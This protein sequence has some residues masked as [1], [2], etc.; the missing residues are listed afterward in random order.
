MAKTGLGRGLGALLGGQNPS[1]TAE[2]P[3]D[4]QEVTE[5]VPANAVREVSI[6]S[7]QPCPSQP[8]KDFERQPLEELAA[9]IEVN[10]IL[11]PLVA[12]TTG[13]GQL[14]LIAGERRWRAAQIAGLE[15]VPVIVREASDSQVLELALVENLQ[16][17]DLNPVE[18]AQ[19]YALLMEAFDLTQEATA[20][21]VGKSR[22][23]VANAVRLLNLPEP[24][25]THLRQGRLSVGHAKV[26]LG[27]EG[28]QQ[29]TLVA[30]RVIKESLSVRETEELTDKL[31]G[32]STGKTSTQRSPQT[33]GVHVTSLENRLK[34]KLGTK[35]SL[36]YREGKGALTIKYF[37]DDDLERILKILDVET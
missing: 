5:M 4:S 6:D 2:T 20:Q 37:S 32:G 33:R 29:Q 23:A 10:G 17:E 21:R 3:A 22:A 31:Q 9:S 1:E 36:T 30:N 34:E 14:E 18:E 11:Q 15:T 7:V 28:A 25:Q 16:R 12:R 24:L 13:E 19:G 8:R 27:L 35:V 26:I